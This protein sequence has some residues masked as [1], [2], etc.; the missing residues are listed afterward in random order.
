MDDRDVW[1]EVGYDLEGFITDGYAGETARQNM[2]PEFRNGEYG[3]G[4]VAGVTRLVAR[5]A[6]EREV[7]LQGVRVEPRRPRRHRSI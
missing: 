3:A 7:T 6:Q 4:L 5:I 1:T 2:I